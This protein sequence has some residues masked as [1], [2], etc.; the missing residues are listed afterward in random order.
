[1]KVA[2]SAVIEIAQPP[3]KVFDYITTPQNF[4]RNFKGFAVIPGMLREELVGGGE[5]FEVGTVRRVY[6]ADKSVLVEKVARLDR[7]RLF[8]YDIIGG[9]KFPLALLARTGHTEWHVAPAPSGTTLRWDYD[10]TLTSPLAV[11]LAAPVVKIFMRRAMQLC[12]A[13]MK[14]ALE[15]H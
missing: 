5:K 6:G 8:A 10:F 1:M 4:P 3:E 14:A 7:P 13:R 11:P 15:S 2:T 9:I 12:L